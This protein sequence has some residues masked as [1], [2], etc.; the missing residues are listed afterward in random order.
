MSIFD[1]DRFFNQKQTLDSRQ[2]YSSD[3]LF[4]FLIYFQTENVIILPRNA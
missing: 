1:A 2:E 4:T 3:L